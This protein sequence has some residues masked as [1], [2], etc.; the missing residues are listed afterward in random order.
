[1]SSELPATLLRQ[2]EELS[3]QRPDRV[4]RLRG[5]IDAEPLE[6]LIFRGFS[7]STTHPTAFDPDQTVLPDG[8]SLE[9][10]ELLRGPLDPAAEDCL[11]GPL[12]PERFLNPQAWL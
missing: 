10:A 2:L 12:A 11:A 9:G 7:C 5:W 6:L 8:A 1:V 4:L 3:R